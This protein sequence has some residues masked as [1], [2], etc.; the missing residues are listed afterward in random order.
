MKTRLG[1]LASGRGTN[2]QAVFD[3]CRSGE[4][5]AAPAVVIS[6][7]RNSG[8]LSRAQAHGVPCYCLNEAG[9]ADSDE[10]DQAIVRTLDRHLVDWVLALGYMKKIGPRVLHAYRN[11]ILNLH[12]S[13]LPKFGGQGMY[14]LRVHR[15]VLAAGETETGVTIHLVNKEYDQGPILAQQPVPVMPGDTAE[16]LAG[17]VQAVEHTFLIDTLARLLHGELKLPEER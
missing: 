13:L 4:L 9:F 1:F 7:N 17:R 3:A 14:G 6:N 2:M 16:S 5:D 11:R 15:A 8:A 10:L 12:P